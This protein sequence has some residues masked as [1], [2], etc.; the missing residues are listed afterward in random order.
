MDRTRRPGALQ[1]YD[2]AGRVDDDDLACFAPISRSGTVGLGTDGASPVV[3]RSTDG[4]RARDFVPSG[5]RQGI[6]RAI[7]AARF[8][9]VDDPN[10]DDS[11]PPPRQP[12]GGLASTGGA[13]PLGQPPADAQPSA[14]ARAQPD[15]RRGRDSDERASASGGEPERGDDAELERGQLEVGDGPAALLAA[16]PPPWEEGEQFFTAPNAGENV[17]PCGRRGGKWWLA[18]GMRAYQPRYITSRGTMESRVAKCHCVPVGRGGVAV[19]V[20]EGGAAYAGLQTCGSVWACPHCAPRICAE[21]AENITETVQAHGQDRVLMM[22][23]T[24]RHGMGDDLGRLRDGVAVAWGKMRGGKARTIWDAQ[25]GLVGMVRAME[26]THGVTHGWHPHLHILVFVRDVEAALASVPELVQQW[27]SAVRR[28]LG[29]DQVPDAEHGLTLVPCHDAAYLAKLGLEIT[30]TRTKAAKHGNRSPW[31]IAVECVERGEARDVALW[32][33]YARAFH[34][35]CQL[36]GL[37]KLR[38]CLGL[39][40]ERTDEEIAAEELPAVPVAILDTPTWYALGRLQAAQVMLLEV[41]EAAWV[42]GGVDAAYA[43]VV[44]YV[45]RRL[46]DARG[47]RAPPD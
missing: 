39:G 15:P 37:T 21:R 26:V 16:S 31:E 46:G 2:D 25:V 14:G 38:K 9:W 43:A 29:E 5:V 44:E 18:V 27:Q 41:A 22:T 20:R 24:I 1:E 13:S 19:R 36:T 34:G 6:R 4:S 35:K 40:A 28:T 17:A 45:T 12:K 11:P 42:R 33:T 23:L 7:S 32:Q 10:P 3:P 47:V 8:A 30:F